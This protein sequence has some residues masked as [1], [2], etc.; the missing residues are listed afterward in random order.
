VLSHRKRRFLFLWMSNPWFIAENM[1]L[2]V[3]ISAKRLAE[4]VK[5]VLKISRMGSFTSVPA[6]RE[7]SQD[8]DFEVSSQATRESLIS[9]CLSELPQYAKPLARPF[10]SL[11]G[12]GNLGSTRFQGSNLPNGKE[13]GTDEYE[14]FIS[15]GCKRVSFV[16]QACDYAGGVNENAGRFRILSW[17]VL[18]QALAESHD[19]F[20]GLPEGTLDWNARRLHIL[21]E[22]I[23]Y[24]PDI[25][26][27][28][29][30]D[31]FKFLKSALNPLGYRGIFCSKPDSPC[32]YLENNNG[33]D[34]CAL[35]FRH[36]KFELISASSRVIE[37]WKIQSNQVCIL[38]N[39]LLRETGKHISIATT[40]LKARQGS[41]LATMRNEQGKDV[42]NFL[43]SFGVGS[44][45]L[46]L[47]GDFNSVP[48][49]PVQQTIK[50]R[51]AVKSA[52]SLLYNGDEPPFT[53]WKVRGDGEY[54]HTLD[55]IFYN[56][57]CEIE[58]VLG[59]PTPDQVGPTRLP[60]LNYASD[61]I[62]IACDVRISD[63]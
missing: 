21:H 43:N 19:N 30:V 41:L 14:S 13:H 4:P 9:R 44:R 17:N 62:A 34:G 12:T 24:N 5:S 29:E 58:S 61:H 22:I 31:H 18:A 27:L 56:K 39:L 63:S 10:I 45:P 59:L 40:H 1:I 26:C 55:Y 33:P 46:I 48:T 57:F 51:L 7:D 6:L 20:V 52:Y 23:A 50:N 49:E 15:N 11:S 37:I 60:N 2:A 16:S 25:I 35:F 38:A 8:V 54:C 36:D 53:T 28:Q 32:I 42:S 47:C 3:R